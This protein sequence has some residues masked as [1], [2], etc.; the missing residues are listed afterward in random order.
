MPSTLAS[1]VLYFNSMRL[2]LMYYSTK[3]GLGEGRGSKRSYTEPR[4]PP[5]NTGRQ[6]TTNEFDKP[7]HNGAMAGGRT[8]AAVRNE[9]RREDAA[10]AI[11]SASARS[12]AMEE[13]SM[14]KI[15]KIA[16]MAEPPKE[17]GISMALNKAAPSLASSLVKSRRQKKVER[18]QLEDDAF[19]V[20]IQTESELSDSLH[21]MNLIKKQRTEIGK[22]R[23]QLVFL[24]SDGQDML[25]DSL[26][27]VSDPRQ[28]ELNLYNL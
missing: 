18:W 7:C 1:S 4:L 19:F 17:R 15:H 23:N 5:E 26:P 3:E 10:M 20:G 2:S 16:C 12:K 14:Q 27:M 21:L 6:H 9:E 24:Q 25:D 28:D 8:R 13:I 22:L 11:L